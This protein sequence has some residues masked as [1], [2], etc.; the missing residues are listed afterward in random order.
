VQ[1]QENSWNADAYEARADN[2]V[3]HL[4]VHGEL[5]ENVSGCVQGRQHRKIGNTQQTAARIGH[6]QGSVYQVYVWKT[7]AEV[8]FYHAHGV[9]SISQG[10]PGGEG[11]PSWG[12]PEVLLGKEDACWLE[13]Y[14]HIR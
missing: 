5:P 2:Q 6:G 4:L 3:A 14:L 13:R 7:L 11:L 8:S 12:R 10:G 1:R 9:D